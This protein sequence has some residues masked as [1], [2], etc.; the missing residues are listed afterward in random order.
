MKTDSDCI[1]KFWAAPEQALFNQKAI[2]K[3]LC[4]S[5]AWLERGRWAGYGPVFRKIGRRVIYT[6][7]DV[8]DWLNRHQRVQ[9]TSEYGHT[10]GCVS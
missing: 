9:S 5:T 1:N 6:K 8:V 3:V 7:H 4:C 10:A 2:A